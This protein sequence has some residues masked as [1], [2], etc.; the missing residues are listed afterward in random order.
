MKRAKI[1]EIYSPDVDDL[2]SYKP[3]NPDNFCI[4]LQINV[5]A[6]N[7]LEK[8]F[9]GETFDIEVYTPKWLL[10]AYRNDEIILPKNSLIV[11]EYDFERIYERLK[12]LIESC[13]GSSWD[14]IAEQV[15]KFAAWEFNNYENDL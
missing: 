2:R 8:D 3:E 5:G 15:G 1:T 11:F 4:L 9:S 7:D 12:H 13:E 6:D 14:E 10:S